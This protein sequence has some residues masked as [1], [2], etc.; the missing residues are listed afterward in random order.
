MNGKIKIAIIVVV[1]LIVGYGIFYINDYYH[2]EKSATDCL[3]GSDDVNV[4]RISSGLFVDGKGNDTALIF[5]PG[6]KV[7]YSAYL[8][9]LCRLAGEGV[10]CYLVEMPFNIAFLGANSADD[11]M[12]NSSYDHY[13][14]AGHSL[15]GVTASSYVNETNKTDGLILLAA[16]PTGEIHK[17]VLSLYG[18]NDGVLNKEKYDEAKPLV[19]G[20]FTEH[21]IDG[22]NHAQFGNYGNQSG[23]N[24]A[25]I[26]A[27]NQQKQSVVEIINFI[28]QYT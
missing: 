26:T 15:G 4:S 19:K 24:P 10:D 7:E 6:G 27:E 25:N 17:P 11:I 14:I 22:A 3:N 13:F 1:L 21:V 2:A 5:Y 20:N 9:M 28:N 18:S 8:P 12:A 16:Y 23:D